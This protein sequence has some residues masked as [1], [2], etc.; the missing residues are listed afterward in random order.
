MYPLIAVEPD[1]LSFPLPA[2][3]TSLISPGDVFVGIL[4]TV[5]VS[6]LVALIWSRDKH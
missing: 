6:T 2:P 3:T 5:C 1:D 4:V